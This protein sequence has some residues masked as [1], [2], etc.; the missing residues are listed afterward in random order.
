VTH[1][2]KK[3]GSNPRI[4]LHQDY[5]KSIIQL[6]V[7]LLFFFLYGH[8]IGCPIKL[9][10]G[11][12]CLGCG[13]TRAWISVASFDFHMAAYYHPLWFMP[14]V[15]VGIYVFIKPKSIKVYNAF[16]VFSF[17]AFVVIYV[18]RLVGFSTVVEHSI[19]E[20]L[21]YKLFY[22]AFC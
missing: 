14:L 2:T 11:I 1:L 19:E 17:L 4:E 10:L 3:M 18:I 13:M 12:P 5:I 7:L 9:L 6:F 16:L 8:L 20:G 21:L 22:H 15:F